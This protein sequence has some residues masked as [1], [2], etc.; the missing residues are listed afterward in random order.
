[1]SP[2]N[3][4]AE[5][6]ASPRSRRSRSR[7]RGAAMLVLFASLAL[8]GCKSGSSGP[9]NDDW[10][11]H[12]HDAAEQ[13]FSPMTQIDEDSIDRLGLAWSLDLPDE[14]SLEATPLAVNGKLFFTGGYGNVYGVD[15]VTGKMDW[16]YNHN[17]MEAAP[18][19]A[20][21]MFGVNR[22]AAYWDGKVYAA[23]RD[24]V[25]VA[26]DA[27]TGKP[28]WTTKF[29]YP[30]SKATSTGAPRVMDGKVI[31]GSSGGD[32]G[33]RGFVTAMD[34][35]TGKVLWRFFVTP[36]S[37]AD[38]EGKDTPADKI[39]AAT[40]SGDWWTLGGGGGGSPYSGITYDP[41]LK[42]VY[43][44]TGNGSPWNCHMRSKD[45]DDNLFLASVVALDADTGEYK[46]H[47]QYNPRECWDWKATSEMILTDMKVGDQTRKVLMQ[48]P[49]N[50]F[51]YVIDR[52]TGKL[53]SADAYAKQNWA[54]R[55]DLKTGKPVER[56]GIRFEN[57]PITLYPGP[58]GA[59]NWQ[60]SSYSPQTG[61]VY[62]PYIQAGITYA[63]DPQALEMLKTAAGKIRYHQ[64]AGMMTAIDPKDPMDDRGSLIAWDPVKKNIRWRVDYPTQSTTGTVVTAGGVVFHATL[65][66][67]LYAYDAATGKRLW[68]FD[69]KVGI[70]APPITFGFKGKQYVSILTGPG[71]TPGEGGYPSLQQGWK[72]GLHPRRLLTFALDGKAVLPDTPAPDFK[73]ASLDKPD[74]QLD[75]VKVEYGARLYHTSCSACHGGEVIGGGAAPD[76]RESS[77]AFDPVTLQQVVTGGA[78]IS[79]GM[80]KLDFT[81][82]ELND[83]YQYIRY[84]AREEIKQRQAAGSK[85][86]AQ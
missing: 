23:S 64:G 27:R 69:T 60:P 59:H 17:A 41:Q 29:A 68:S 57:G 5:S 12:G 19:N 54:E 70:V 84:A 14:V 75:P 40:W 78:L 3:P 79:R 26:L 49:S 55:I 21:R 30:G 76:L 65:Q 43:I 53:L 58:L 36:A 73:V 63:A 44:G 50:G 4:I 81:S 39:A 66:G 61:L 80:P 86:K 10:A 34:G 1:M 67:H 25:M 8:A 24:G 77:A 33:A 9:L 45:G 32:Y 18:E 56:P 11:M 31:I 82:A 83:I 37:A 74:L 22:G 52:Q 38:G 42:Q 35:R 20:A 2:I 51:F 7:F 72:Y 13:R 46:W 71:G 62:M 47:Y 85:P 28:L 48:A 6:G 16:V 15:A